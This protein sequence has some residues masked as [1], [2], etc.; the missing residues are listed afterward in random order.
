MGRVAFCAVAVLV[1]C[2]ESTAP[3]FEAMCAAEPGSP[4]REEVFETWQ[5]EVAGRT[6]SPLWRS[7]ALSRSIME[8]AMESDGFGELPDGY[9]PG[10]QSSV[11]RWRESG[12]MEVRNV[13][14]A[15]E[16]VD[17]REREMLT[18]EADTVFV[19]RCGDA[20]WIQRG[21]Y[22]EPM[23]GFARPETGLVIATG[24]DATQPHGVVGYL[25]PRD[26]LAGAH[27]DVGVGH[28][29]ALI[30]RRPGACR[31]RHTWA[32]VLD[33]VG[34]AGHTRSCERSPQREVWLEL[35]VGEGTAR[36]VQY[37]GD[38]GEVV[39]LTGTATDDCTI[40]V[41][42]EESGDAW[43]LICTDDGGCIGTNLDRFGTRCE[44]LWS[45]QGFLEDVTERG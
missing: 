25:G 17:F 33:R 23:F 4:E 20:V 1:G 19:Q 34:A 44:T 36:L 9:L 15:A 3:S 11:E 38:D 40:H 14:L 39:E 31:E 35:H 24:L 8:R 12:P 37:V 29:E 28:E 5:L 22:G 16:R 26:S 18:V 30:A 10:V 45:I 13:S 41:E 7:T 43:D 2:A 27:F 6:V 32:G 21:G 42:S